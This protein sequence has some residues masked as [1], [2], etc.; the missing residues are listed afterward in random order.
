MVKLK[1]RSQLMRTVS[2][3]WFS[4]DDAEEDD[5]LPDWFSDLGGEEISEFQGP[6]DERRSRCIG[7]SSSYTCIIVPAFSSD[8]IEERPD[9]L[10]DGDFFEGNDEEVELLPLAVEGDLPDWLSDLS[11]EESQL[12]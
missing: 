8:D 4:N 2:L 12:S 1:A 3:T 10:A 6:I 11:D 7:R 5:E 9:W